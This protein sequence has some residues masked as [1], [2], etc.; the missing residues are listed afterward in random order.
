LGTARLTDAGFLGASGQLGN[1]LLRD[2]N[3]VRACWLQMACCGFL[4]YDLPALPGGCSLDGAEA[5]CRAQ[6]KA[7]PPNKALKL[8]K[9]EA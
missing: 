2:Q 1:E 8:T 5:D 3:P 7:M 9:R 4:V 6:G